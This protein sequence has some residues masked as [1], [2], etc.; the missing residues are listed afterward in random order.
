MAE[1]R[2]LGRFASLDGL[3]GVAALV[4]VF[5]HALLTAPSLARAYGGPYAGRSSGAAWWLT[6]TPAHLFWAGPEAVYVF[7][8]LSGFVLVLPTM[9]ARFTWLSYYPRRILRLYLPVAGGVAFAVV[10]ALLVERRAIP[11]ASWWLSAHRGTVTTSGI[12]HNVL[13][14]KGTSFLNSPLWSLKWEVWFS[15]LLPLYI[16]G[17]AV[18][19]RFLAPSVILLLLLIAYSAD[20]ARQKGIYLPMFAL[21]VLMAKNW[22]RLPTLSA[23][24]MRALVLMLPL[25]LTARWWTHPFLGDHSASIVAVEALGAAAT[26]YLFARWSAARSCGESRSLQWLG[27]RSF[28]L[29]L[30]HEPVVVSVALLLGGKAPAGVTLAIGLPVALLAAAGFFRAV[31][32]P[33]HRLARAAGRRLA[34]P[35]NGVPALE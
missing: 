19:H 28:S 20:G 26:V 22:E 30:V 10:T 34:P 23:P 11:G 24:R 12:W 27:R 1:K 3:R 13:L 31:E 33:S 21:G 32:L 25:L 2:E 4:V 9:S 7:F 16:I 5:H 17:A 29:Y 14:L 18:A 6:Y 35:S 8:V 15:L